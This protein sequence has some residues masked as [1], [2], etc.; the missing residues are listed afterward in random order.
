MREADQLRDPF[1]LFTVTLQG[2]GPYEANRYAKNT[3]KVEGNLPLADRQVL[4]TYA[5]GVKEADDSLKMLMDWAKERDRETIIV[6]FGD[7]LPPL[8][9]VYPNTGYM[10]DVTASRKGPVGQMKAQHETPLVVWSNKT[11]PVKDIG[12]ILSLIHI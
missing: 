4:E 6:L 11:G 10:N 12:T 7:H 8:N 9:T 3:I 5:Q 1:F 2:H